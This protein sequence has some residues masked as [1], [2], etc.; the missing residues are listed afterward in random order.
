MAASRDAYRLK[1]LKTFVARERAEKARGRLN[2]SD[3]M[4]SDTSIN[5][6]N[7]SDISLV[8]NTT[9]SDE[10]ESTGKRNQRK[11]NRKK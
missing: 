3:S 4:H 5:S 8:S 10:L 6:D 9:Y 7:V 2:Q 11:K 1:L